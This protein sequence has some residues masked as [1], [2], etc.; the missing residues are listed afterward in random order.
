LLESDGID[1]ANVVGEAWKLIQALYPRKY[2]SGDFRA[3]YV[4]LSERASVDAGAGRVPERTATTQKKMISE[5]TG[6]YRNKRKNLA[7]RKFV[8]CERFATEAYKKDRNRYMADQIAKL[9]LHIGYL[10]STKSDM[11]RYRPLSNEYLLK[12]V[13]FGSVDAYVLL[14]MNAREAGLV[15]EFGRYLQEGVKAGSTRCCAWY[16]LSLLGKGEVERGIEHLE[17]AVRGGDEFAMLNKA[18]FLFNG[19]Y[20]YSECIDAAISL[21]D[22]I[23]AGEFHDQV[24]QLLELANQ[25]AN[26]YFEWGMKCKLPHPAESSPSNEAGT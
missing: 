5:A 1:C 23:Q 22:S 3:A 12:A 16:A 11:D 9:C 7:I 4:F 18:I 21:L 25:Y 8:E 19:E 15:D 26:Q 2:G 14:A 13:G 24:G 10:Y 17:K 20:G 6:A